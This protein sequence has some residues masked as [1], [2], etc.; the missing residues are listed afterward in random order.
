MTNEDEK[1]NENNGER[2]KTDSITSLFDKTNEAVTRQEAANKKTEELLNRQ[3]ELYAKQKLGGRSM[4]GEQKAPEKPKE[5]T[6]K[7]YAKRVMA[8]GLN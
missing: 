4:A 7:E 1:N 3:E 6:P 5:E 8:G 2:E